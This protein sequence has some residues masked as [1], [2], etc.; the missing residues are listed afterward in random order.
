M[1]ELRTLS[2]A[3]RQGVAYPLAHHRPYVGGR[4]LVMQ[5]QDQGLDR[6]FCLI[7]VAGGQ[8]ILTGPSQ[9]FGDRAGADNSTRMWLSRNDGSAHLIRI[10]RQRA[11]LC[12]NHTRS[13]LS[14]L[15]W[16][17]SSGQATVAGTGATTSPAT[18][19]PPSTANPSVIFGPSESITL[20]R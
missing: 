20:V 17:W 11:D 10:D 2:T 7:A 12:E 15:V 3:L 18:S 6:R 4:N 13:T 14:L 9:T 16:F 1:T 8:I 19:G 5:S